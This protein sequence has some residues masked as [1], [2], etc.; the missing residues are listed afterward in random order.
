MSVQNITETITAALEGVG[1][2]AGSY[3]TYVNPV[4]DAL[5]EREYDITEQVIETVTQ[6]FGV[7]REQVLPYVENIGL[8]VRPEP[9]PEP[10]AT[11]V[12]EGLGEDAPAWA[13]ALVEKVESAVSTVNRL[14][15]AA[16]NRY[17]IT[18]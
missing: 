6:N 9:E 12:A 1:V 13:N 11:P 10:E 15:E 3:S 16:R 18:L 17:G 14:A 4:A 5:L 2:R 8:S 7:S